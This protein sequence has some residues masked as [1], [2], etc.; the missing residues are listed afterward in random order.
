MNKRI[1]KIKKVIEKIKIE[2]ETNFALLKKALY[3]WLV[4]EV[5]ERVKKH[6]ELNQSARQE[7]LKI[8]S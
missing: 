6:L 5:D 2:R 8:R 1:E 4:D 3:R 7:I